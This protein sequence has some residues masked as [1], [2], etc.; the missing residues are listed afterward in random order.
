VQGCVL[1][2][3]RLNTSQVKNIMRAIVTAF[4]YIIA[5]TS[6]DDSVGDGSL[7]GGVDIHG[8]NGCVCAPCGGH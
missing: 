6:T 3:V 8:S 4:G 2:G 5:N 1:F 7:A